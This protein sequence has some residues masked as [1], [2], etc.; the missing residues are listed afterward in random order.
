MQLALDITTKQQVQ[1]CWAFAVDQNKARYKKYR[2]VKKC[3]ITACSKEAKSF[4]VRA[5]M[6]YEEAILLLP[7]LRVMIYNW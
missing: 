7:Q 1:H 6:A 2:T 3:V 4:G 5:G